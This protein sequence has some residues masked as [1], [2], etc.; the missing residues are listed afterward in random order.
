MK[1]IDM[2]EIYGLYNRPKVKGFEFTEPSMTQQQY[3]FECDLNNIVDHNMHF[4]DPAFVTKLRLQGLLSDEKAVYGDFTNVKDY[5][6]ALETIHL[7]QEQF[8]QLPAKVRD[9]FENNP[10]L[11]LDFCNRA[12]N[13]SDLYAQGVDLGLFEKT[14]VEPVNP[15]VAGLKTESDS[16]SDSSAQ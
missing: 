7:A 1:G 4:K 8:N 5:Q 2:V 16:V 14:V 3:A 13:D 11:M 6:S 10:A 9:K 15:V 12:V